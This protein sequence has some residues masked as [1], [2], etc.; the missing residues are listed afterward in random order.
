MANDPWPENTIEGNKTDLWVWWHPN[1]MKRIQGTYEDDIES[2]T[3]T[4]WDEEGNLVTT[5]D[6]TP[7]ESTDILKKP[8]II[9]GY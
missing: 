7:A 1:G 9:E 2:G 5:E 8:R 4:W 6:M 3:W